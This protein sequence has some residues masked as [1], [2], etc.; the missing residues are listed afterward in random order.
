MDNRKFFNNLAH[1]WDEISIHDKNKLTKIID[2]S[3]IKPNAKILDVGT[4]TGVLIKYLLEKSP[5]HIHAVDISENMIAIAKTK[6]NDD[7]VKFTNVDVHQL[8]ESRFD[9]IF[10]YS[11]YPH[12]QDKDALFSH[13]KSMLNEDGKIVIAHSQS[14]EAINSV[15]RENENTKNDKLPPVEVT[16]EIM[17]S[18]FNTNKMVDNSDMYYI[19]GINI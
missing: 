13:L 4:G 9:Y 5:S 1:K 2:L 3:E 7:R 16:A 19:S 10:L 15:H 11:V 12:F 14:K 8:K 17:S 18:Y 6:Y